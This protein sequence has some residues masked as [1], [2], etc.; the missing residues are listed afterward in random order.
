MLMGDEMQEDILQKAF[1]SLWDIMEM[2][3]AILQNK[4]VK[5]MLQDPQRQS[6][7]ADQEGFL[8]DFS[9]VIRS[10]TGSI[11][12]G[13]ADLLQDEAGTSA[14]EE[15]YSLIEESRRQER[16]KVHREKEQE[17]KSHREKVEKLPEYVAS[18]RTLEEIAWK[19]SE[20]TRCQLCETRKRA[21]PGN[22]VVNPK[23]MIIG[24][25][26]GAEEDASGE[27]FVGRA[28]KYLDTWMGA[29]K[30][31]RG[32]DLFI[33]NIIKCR[34]PGNRDPLPDEQKA[35]IPFL[36]RQIRIL[37]PKAI[38]CVGR[39]A[40]QILTRQDVG[41]GRMRGPVYRYEGIPLIVTYH[42]SAVLRNP[43]SYRAP[44]WEDLQ[45][46]SAIIRDAGS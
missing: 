5:S 13:D 28:G 34:P 14:V 44:V 9:A 46:L 10:V 27:P 32:R 20:C 4:P 29:I 21:V 3:E 38:L 26:P 23:V 45:K 15:A 1:E 11:S 43:E 30:L 2:E 17:R 12:T 41:I 36:R 37:R 31:F 22:G 7:S 40:A 16:E 42:P 25:A 33:G 8:P 6:E 18:C 39:I 35:C 19:V 24:E